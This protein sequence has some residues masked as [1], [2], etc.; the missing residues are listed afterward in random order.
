MARKYH[1]DKNPAGRPM[2][3][4]ITKAYERLQ[5]GVA[6]G[7][8]PQPWRVLLMLR[9]Q[10]VLFSRCAPQ[11]A[12]FKY[13]GYPQ[14]LEVV[15]QAT[16]ES[17]A[18]PMAA[19]GLQQVG[20]AGEGWGGLL[21]GWLGR[22]LLRPGAYLVSLGPRLLATH[23]TAATPSPHD[24]YTLPWPAVRA[25]AGGGGAVLADLRLLRAQRGGADALRRRGGAGPAA[26]ALQGRHAGGRLA[27]Q[28]G[29][30]HPDAHA[31]VG[32]SSAAQL[33]CI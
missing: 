24:P 28:P 25:G 3:L 27:H 16:A 30:H 2:F 22:A 20:G 7:Q 21:L 14:L 17:G 11:L 15:Q 13:A 23:T 6:G 4:Q 10:C 18:G 29:G 1:P 12:P 19:E 8:G 32:P 33:S 26:V 9:S 31:Q 5:A